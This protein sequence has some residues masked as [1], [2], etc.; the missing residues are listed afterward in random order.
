MKS[1]GLPVLVGNSFRIG[2][3]IASFR[4][5][6]RPRCISDIAAPYLLWCILWCRLWGQENAESIGIIAIIGTCCRVASNHRHRRLLR[7]RCEWPR[8]CAADERDEVATLHSITSLALASK[9]AGT[10]MPSILAICAL[11]T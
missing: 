1:R 7:A 4:Y 10:V 5:H 6:W 2:R 3:G 8:R 9:V 11:M